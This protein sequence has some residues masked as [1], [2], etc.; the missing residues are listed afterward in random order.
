MGGVYGLGSSFRDF[1]IGNSHAGRY[2]SV[3]SLAQA[4]VQESYAN[5]QDRMA[6]RH[7]T[8]VTAT[9]AIDFLEPFVQCAEVTLK[10]GGEADLDTP[11][12]LDSAG[13]GLPKHGIGMLIME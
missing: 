7:Y 3:E 5:C 13:R 2:V 10:A 4:G 1:H 9:P 6:Y 12:A 11:S 8:Q